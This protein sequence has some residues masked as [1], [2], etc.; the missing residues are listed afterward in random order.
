MGRVDGSAAHI[1]RRRHPAVRAERLH[2]MD[3]PDNIDDRVEGA[4]FMKVDLVYRDPVNRGFN[5][6]EPCKQLLRTIPSLRRQRRTIDQCI[7]LCQRAMGVRMPRG[8][9]AVIEML[10]LRAGVAVVRVIIVCMATC[11]AGDMEFRGRD[12]RTRHALG[13]D[14]RRIDGE[15]AEGAAEILER[16]AE[17]EQGTQNH[18]PG[19]AG[20]AVEIQNRQT[21]IILSRP[22]YSRL[23]T[24]GFDKREVPLLRE[25][26]MIDDIDPHDVACVHHSGGER[27]VVGTRRRIA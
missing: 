22:A 18:V 10:R 26:Q 21:S 1:Q 25:D 3:G 20:E 9:T 23:Q 14:C 2:C 4:H 17:V 15:T 13:P 7:H 19:S 27:E 8:F 16:Q 5:F 12:A 24:P 6:P 11:L